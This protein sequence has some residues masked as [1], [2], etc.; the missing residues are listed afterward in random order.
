MIRMKGQLLTF[1]LL[2]A[3]YDFFICLKICFDRN[4]EIEC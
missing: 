3:A 2:F 4:G 1:S